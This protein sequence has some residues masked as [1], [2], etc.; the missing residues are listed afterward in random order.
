MG[1]RFTSLAAIF[2]SLVMTAVIGADEDPNSVIASEP[3]M[4]AK[5]TPPPPNTSSIRVVPVR[6]TP[7]GD[8]VTLA[9]VFPEENNLIEKS[10]VNS[11]IRVEGF[12]LGTKSDFPRANEIYNSRDGQSVHIFID[13][14]PYF[15]ENNSLMDA[16]FDNQLY[17][18][19]SIT[20]QIPFSLKPGMHVMRAF[21]ARSYGESLKGDSCYKTR[22]FYYQSKKTNYTFDPK[23][24][25]LTYNEPQGK[26]PFKEDRPVLLD[27]MIA[28][29][30][31]SRDGYKVRVSIDGHV[32]RVITTWVPYYVYGMTRGSH[33]IRLELLDA[34]NVPV[35]GPFNDVQREII[36]N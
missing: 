34:D 22:T 29:C 6:P 30:K 7:E 31:L 25:C 32:E 10:K 2:L 15:M 12:A 16:F 4:G 13:D 1:H 33:F 3:S 14:Q 8:N 28:N 17:Y 24:P 27:F 23:A 9:I 26:I 36:L 18:D 19:L 11:Q 5:M 20:F 35:Q 21:P